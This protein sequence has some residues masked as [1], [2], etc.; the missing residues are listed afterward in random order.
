VHQYSYSFSL[1]VV[2]NFQKTRP[3]G[4]KAVEKFTFL[5]TRFVVG[6]FAQKDMFFWENYKRLVCRV[7]LWEREVGPKWSP[8]VYRSQIAG[9]SFLK[10]I[11]EHL[12]K[13]LVLTDE[14]KCDNL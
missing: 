13:C 7:D 4:T 1:K 6:R 5:R 2:E 3:R 14:K 11:E 12:H 8:K 10:K 9:C